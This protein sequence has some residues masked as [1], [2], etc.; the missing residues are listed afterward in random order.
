MQCLYTAFHVACAG[1]HVACAEALLHAGCNVSLRNDTGLTG[2]ELAESLVSVH[3]GTY[4]VICFF[5]ILLFG[6]FHGVICAFIVY[7]HRT[8]QQRAGILEMLAAKHARQGGLAGSTTSRSVPKKAL[9][10]A[11]AVNTSNFKDGL[12]V[13]RALKSELIARGLSTKGS[14]AELRSRLL[15]AAQS[16]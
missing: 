14:K 8:L 15:A 10:T 3:Y 16:Q 1:G 6:D 11:A 5:I 9:P 13:G 4:I 7:A 12:G 2:C